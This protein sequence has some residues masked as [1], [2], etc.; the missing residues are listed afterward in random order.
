[1]GLTNTLEKAGLRR[2]TMIFEQG[3]A[4]DELAQG[5]SGG[6]QSPPTAD[7]A[8]RGAV[9]HRRNSPMVTS[10]SRWG[11]VPAEASRYSSQ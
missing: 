9:P 8:G 4:L 3:L 1:M 10:G 7:A 2:S 6:S 11:D 5:A